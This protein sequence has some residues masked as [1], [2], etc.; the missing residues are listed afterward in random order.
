MN[1]RGCVEIETH[2]ELPKAVRAARR[3]QRICSRNTVVW[4]RT[5]RNDYGIILGFDGKTK[6][7][8]WGRE[9]ISVEEFLGS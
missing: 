2:Q 8:G 1:R 4:V 3:W 5:G 6:L 7:S 9:V